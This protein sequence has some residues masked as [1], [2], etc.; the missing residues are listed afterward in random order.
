MPTFNSNL[1]RIPVDP[2][3]IGTPISLEFI[4]AALLLLPS[5]IGGGNLDA[6]NR[7]IGTI[8]FQDLGTDFVGI[9][10]HSHGSWGDGLV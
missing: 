9:A 6:S 5:I 4:A 1:D 10:H 3:P 7:T 2:I 8:E